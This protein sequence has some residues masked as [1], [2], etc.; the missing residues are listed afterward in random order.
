MNGDLTGQ[1]LHEIAQELWGYPLAGKLTGRFSQ[2]GWTHEFSVVESCPDCQTPLE[3]CRKPYTTSAGRSQKYVAMLC[4]GCA[5]MMT[6]KDLGLGG[7]AALTPRSESAVFADVPDVPDVPDATAASAAKRGR[8]R[9]DRIE[10]IISY[11]RAMEYFEIQSVELPSLADRAAGSDSNRQLIDPLGKAPWERQLDTRNSEAAPDAPVYSY[12]LFPGIF[13]LADLHGAIGSVL[14]TTSTDTEEKSPRGTSALFSLAVDHHGIP[15]WNSLTLASAPWALGRLLRAAGQE[16][17]LNGFREDR[18]EFADQVA[19]RFGTNSV[20]GPGSQ[21]TDP[22]PLN[23]RDIALLSSFAASYLGLEPVFRIDRAVVTRRILRKDEEEAPSGGFLNSLLADDLDRVTASVRLNGAPKGLSSYLGFHPGQRLDVREVTSRQEIEHRLRPELIPAGR[24]PS[25]A[26]DSLST[27]QQLA[28]NTVAGMN[29][30]TQVVVGVNRPPGTGKSTLLRDVVA[31]QVT[32]RARALAACARIE[33]AFVSTQNEFRSG[34]WNHR[35]WSLNPS[36]VGFEMVVASS[37]NGAVENVSKELPLRDALAEQ[38][39]ESNYLAGAAQRVDSK[40]WGLIS[41]VLGRKSN[42]AEFVSNC[43]WG[44]SSERGLRQGPALDAE[45]SAK[46]EVATPADWRKAVADFE[47]AQ[48]REEKIRSERQALFETLRDKP[49]RVAECLEAEKQLHGARVHYGRTMAAVQ[50]AT[51]ELNAAQTL[52][53]ELVDDGRKLFAAQP[54]TWEVILH[55]KKS[56]LRRKSLRAHVQS[57][58][59]LTAQRDEKSRG[60]ATWSASLKQSADDEQA[61]L[62]AV[63]LARNRLSEAQ[64]RLSMASK[65]GE[66]VLLP[67]TEWW[68]DSEKQELEAVWVDRSWNEARSELFL[69]AL[70]LH[71]QFII[72]AWKTHF[73]K[74]VRA[75]MDVV[76][77]KPA[78]EVTAGAV[79]EAWRYLFLLVPVV[80]TTFASLGTMFSD[81]GAD[82]LGW[83]IIDEAGQAVPQAA[84][85]GIWRSQKIVAVGDPLQLEPIVAA[86]EEIQ[87]L[88]RKEFDV[89]DSWMPGRGS[90]QRLADRA[91]SIGTRVDEN[92]EELWIGAPLRAHRRCDEP[93]FS[94]VNDAVYSG[95]MVQ[96]EPARPAF[97]PLRLPLLKPSAWLDVP[98]GQVQGKWRPAEGEALVGLVRSLLAQPLDVVAHGRPAVENTLEA[99]EILVIA[100]FKQVADRAA[101]ILHQAG[102]PL[103]RGK[104]AGVTVGTVHTAQGKDASVVIFL[105]GS[106]PKTSGAR[107]WA[108][109]SPNLLNVAVSRAKHRIYVIGQRDQWAQ[110][111][112]FKDLANALPVLAILDR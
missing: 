56:A 10:S 86:P 77:G 63:A 92:G 43:W 31:D 13:A 4:G 106:D 87:D 110:L 51:D 44:S 95:S 65:S 14:A 29:S 72:S 90:V 73:A 104:N 84:V 11:W 99:G 96:G 61:A 36:L 68:E 98:A 101:E 71:E 97:K 24:W 85:G 19:T 100:P 26:K 53:S 23:V 45:M 7:F 39:R 5:S 83:L 75:A 6:L 47:K 50:N 105:L 9:T 46:A 55:P 60:V 54:T 3:C 48:M 37:N 112:Y 93:M 38:W 69:A 82:S 102:V 28:V 88:V 66:S 16:L 42:R 59:V 76:S 30:E 70:K 21:D 25:T 18:Q 35:F 91:T 20:T 58:S 17:D 1:T 40:N 89:D 32:Q 2:P 80:S 107:S 62:T 64:Q 49:R 41:A 111:P 67:S 12:M 52:L 103:A 109:A 78:H 57:Q 81:V 94:I 22:R 33:D 108:S 79:A 34:K 27:S 8:G 74:G 15:D